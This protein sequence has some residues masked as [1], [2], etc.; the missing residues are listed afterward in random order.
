MY[1]SACKANVVGILLGLVGTAVL[2]LELCPPSR[3]TAL[4]PRVVRMPNGQFQQS[5]TDVAFIAWQPQGQSLIFVLNG[6]LMEYPF[7]T[8]R[9]CLQGNRVDYVC[10]NRQGT[11]AIVGSSV[12][13]YGARTD[14]WAWVID[15]VHF[16]IVRK[17]P[18][19]VV[20]AWWQNGDVAYIRGSPDK[21]FRQ[22]AVLPHGRMRIPNGMWV[23]AVSE[24]GKYWMVRGPI[25][26]S[27]NCNL[28]LYRSPRSLVSAHRYIVRHVGVP[29]DTGVGAVVANERGDVF[30]TSCDNDGIS[31]NLCAAWL[32]PAGQ[33][34]LALPDDD[35]VDI[36]VYACGNEFR[37][38][39][40]VPSPS[41]GWAGANY[42]RFRV[43]GRHVT[44]DRVQGVLIA[45]AASPDGEDAYI[46]NKSGRLTYMDEAS[47]SNYLYIVN[48]GSPP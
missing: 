2:A 4:S 23:M 9:I 38:F 12:G 13:G 25:D 35:A 20:T 21:N 10:W 34:S 7:S 5:G 43:R 36:N 11:K 24:D 6:S 42:Y 18:G 44:A 1:C 15:T 29:Y 45:Y 32:V 37:G 39:Y 41:T 31:L 26:N 40:Y 27:D 48:G 19:D 30:V 16:H 17:L 46:V 33:K 3:G 28:L 14:G 22:T 47:S 8:R